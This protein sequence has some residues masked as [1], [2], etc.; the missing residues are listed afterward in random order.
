MSDRT[1]IANL[2]A[3]DAPGLGLTIDAF[4]RSPLSIDGLV[5][6]RGAISQDSLET[7]KFDIDV[8]DAAFLF[9]KLFVLTGLPCGLWVQERTAKAL[10]TISIGM[11]ELGRGEHA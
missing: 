10:G 9:E 8:L 1:S 6:W 2:G 11:M 4:G 7:A 5:R 3:L